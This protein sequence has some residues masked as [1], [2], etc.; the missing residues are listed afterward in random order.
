MLCTPLFCDE[1]P[2]GNQ[3]SS[4]KGGASGVE[5]LAPAKSARKAWSSMSISNKICQCATWTIITV[6]S[7]LRKDESLDEEGGGSTTTVRS[8]Y[9]SAVGSPKVGGLDASPVEDSTLGCLKLG[10]NWAA[11]CQRNVAPIGAIQARM[12]ENPLNLGPTKSYV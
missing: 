10:F 9:S 5:T 7:M 4:S 3:E 1:L 8:T 6:S 11:L 2:K 12:W